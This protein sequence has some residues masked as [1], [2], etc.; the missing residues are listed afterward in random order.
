MASRA[1]FTHLR[2]HSRAF[3]IATDYNALFD[4]ANGKKR[5]AWNYASVGVIVPVLFSSVTPLALGFSGICLGVAFMKM[6]EIDDLEQIARK[7]APFDRI[8]EK[9]YQ[10]LRRKL[11]VPQVRD[12]LDMLSETL[13]ANVDLETEARKMVAAVNNFEL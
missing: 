3:D 13:D 11:K 10:V 8:P 4:T 2:I 12:V 9:Q 6:L 5:E 7:S 1:L